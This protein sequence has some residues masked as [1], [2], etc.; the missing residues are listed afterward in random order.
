MGEKCVEKVSFHA[1]ISVTCIIY[2]VYLCI[3]IR[4]WFH[5]HW[6]PSVNCERVNEI[7]EEWNHLR[8]LTSVEFSKQLWHS[9][10]AT[11][12]HSMQTWQMSWCQ[13]RK[14]F[15]IYISIPSM[16]N[17]KPFRQSKRNHVK[18]P[19]ATEL[20]ILFSKNEKSWNPF[21][22]IHRKVSRIFLYTV[23]CAWYSQ[24]SRR[25]YVCVPQHWLR[26]QIFMQ[27]HENF[28]YA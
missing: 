12:F 17:A 25:F 16:P 2:L 22:R 27:M 28:S 14:H 9:F 13:M 7:S 6:R 3:R 23:L 18:K 1:T 4:N 15:T 20:L 8:N 26:N 19:N 21:Y 11:T 5:S 24:V 10:A